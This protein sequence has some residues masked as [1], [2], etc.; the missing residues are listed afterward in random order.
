MA[1]RPAI[2]SNRQSFTRS[3]E[4]DVELADGFAFAFESAVS[5]D[6]AR[7]RARRSVA[8]RD[9]EHARRDVG[10]TVDASARMRRVARWCRNDDVD[11][12]TRDFVVTPRRSA[13]R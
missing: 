8:T 2:V 6:V 1:H 9:D 4:V 5:F 3:L 10:A 11:A 7:V 12:R 13:S